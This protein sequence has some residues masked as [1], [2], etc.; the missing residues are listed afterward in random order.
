MTIEND[1]FFQTAIKQ[2][3]KN[4]G[5]YSNNPSDKGGATKYGITEKVA[6][7]NGYSGNMKYLTENFAKEIY[8]NRY[9]LKCNCDIISKYYSFNLAFFVFDFAVNSGVSNASRKLQILLNNLDN[10]GLKIDGIIGKKTLL[11]IE[12]I[13]GSLYLLELNYI[14]KI[15]SYYSSLSQFKTFGKGWVNRVAN[16]IEFLS[17]LDL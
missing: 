15:L 2:V 16:N 10:A 3:L 1:K 7:Q 4:E 14:A 12:S 11:A 13:M 8:Y 6:Q 5:G 17:G 9:W